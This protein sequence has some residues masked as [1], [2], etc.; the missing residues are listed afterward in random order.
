MRWILHLGLCGLLLFAGMVRAEPGVL[1]FGRVSDDPQRHHAQLQALLDYV[2]PRMADVGIREGRVLMAADPARMASYLRHGR[3]DWVTETLFTGLQLIDRADAE[4]LLLSEREGVQRYRSVI[5]VREDS[6]IQSLQQLQ[7]RRLALEHP[8]STSAFLLPVITLIEAGLALEILPGPTHPP[9]EG[10]VG[11]VFAGSEGNI[12]RW[13]ELG[14]VDAGGFSE[15]DLARWEHVSEN[16]FRLLGESRSVPRA[17][18]LVR[19]DLPPQVRDRL[20]ELLLAAASDPEVDPVLRAFLGSS[21]FRAPESGD[22]DELAALRDAA[23]QVR[24][25]IE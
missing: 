25:I 23:R 9:I 21:R 6:P 1:V 24:Q 4:L 10:A 3:V 7:G 5:F 11:Y 19:G 14:V 18:E 15:H 20:R 12:A 17:M 8:Q 16:G 2:V 22:L 13:V